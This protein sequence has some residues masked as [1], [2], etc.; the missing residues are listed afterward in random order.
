MLAGNA[1]RPLRRQVGRGPTNTQWPCPLVVTRTFS[2]TWS[3]AGVRLGY[4][5]G[6]SWFVDDLE[7]VVLARAVRLASP[8]GFP[9]ARVL[10]TLRRVHPSCAS[11]AVGRPGETF[12]GA[13]PE[14]L[15]R[16]D[17][18]RVGQS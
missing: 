13:A 14:R 3:M 10:D 18:R 8:A 5:I 6:P 16:L 4:A 11:F 2:K 15:L 1:D 17:G 12:L 7:K 9:V